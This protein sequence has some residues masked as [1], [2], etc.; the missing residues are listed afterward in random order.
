MSA[1]RHSAIVN[2]RPPLDSN[3][4]IP[5]PVLFK[6]FSSDNSSFFFPAATESYDAEG[7]MDFNTPASNSDDLGI[8]PEDSSPSAFVRSVDFNVMFLNTTYGPTDFDQYA[9]LTSP[10][11]AAPLAPSTATAAAAAAAAAS[12]LPASTT[13]SSSSSSSATPAP[14]HNHPVV[15]ETA[16][17]VQRRLNNNEASKRARAKRRER[18][19]C[20][21][22]MVSLHQCIV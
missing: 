2:G 4:P 1:L 20:T 11:A 3:S 8:V 18:E 13:T 9:P 21:S 14:L 15:A 6:T 5:S 12:S 17:Q 22:G 16:Y 19:V 10:F 7:D